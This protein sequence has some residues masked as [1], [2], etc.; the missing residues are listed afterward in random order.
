MRSDSVVETLRCTRCGEEKP[1]DQFSKNGQAVGRGGRH[2]YCKPCAQQYERERYA[3]DPEAFKQ[4]ARRGVMKYKYGI[5][6]EQYDEMV[7]QREGRCDICK[8]VPSG[9]LQLDHDHSCCPGQR[10]CGKCIRGL[11]C[12]PCNVLLGLAQDDLDRLRAALAY[13]GG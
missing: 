12:Q 5:T 6:V 13:L 1:C 7:R 9:R 10:T 3:R 11:L 2:F 4:K 8:T